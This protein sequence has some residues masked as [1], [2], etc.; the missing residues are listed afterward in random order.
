MNDHLVQFFKRYNPV[1]QQTNL[2]KFIYLSIRREV[3][4]CTGQQ[5]NVATDDQIIHL[6]YLFD[7][8]SRVEF[9]RKFQK[10][11]CQF[12]GQGPTFKKYGLKIKMSSLHC[13]SSNA[14]LA[15][16]PVTQPN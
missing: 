6:H 2:N 16:P 12:L 15:A 1:R 7:W 14:L 9:S 10:L 8:G 13:Y 11:W 3:F 5:L 4:R